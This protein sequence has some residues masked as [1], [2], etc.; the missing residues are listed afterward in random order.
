MF[1]ARYDINGLGKPLEDHLIS[2]S[3]LTSSNSILKLY[4]KIIGLLHDIGKYSQAF[5]DYLKNAQN[6]DE[7]YEDQD[8]RG[9][10]D[11]SS[12]GAQFIVKTMREISAQTGDA[13]L[14]RL[15]ELIARIV[16]H[17]VAGHHSGLLNGLTPEYG[18]SLEKRLTK[19]LE[20]YAKN[21]APEIRNK[22][23]LLAGALLEDDNLQSICSWIDE[24]ANVSGRDAFSLQFAVRMLFSALVDADRLHSEK[25]GNPDQWAERQAIRTESPLTLLKKLEDHLETLGKEGSMNQIRRQVSK[26][27]RDAGTQDRGFF[28]LTVPTGGGKT[29]ASLRFAL[30]HAIKH[31]LNRIIY[32]IPYTSIIDQNAEVFRGVMDADGK[33]NNVLE[34]HSNLEPKRET[35]E[36]RLLA[37][38]WN[39]P[40]VVTTSVQFFESLF[41]NRPSPCRRLHSVSNSVVILDEVQTVPVRYLQAITWALEELVENY[42]CTVMLCTATQPVLDSRKI[43]GDNTKDNH[44]IGLQNIHPIID[45]PAKL[46]K[47][48]KRVKILEIESENPLSMPEIAERIIEHADK[49]KSVLSIVNTKRNASALFSELT[50][51]ERFAGRLF[52]LSTTMCP[53]HRKDVIEIIKRLS[54]Y[55][56]NINAHGP[57]VISTQLVEAGIDLDFD[58]VFRSM[59]GVDSIAQAAGRCNREGVLLPQ[60]GKTY[61]YE[62]NEYLGSLI[63][64]IEA[65][66]AG[67]N[68]LSAIENNPNLSNEEKDPLGLKAVQ[69]YFERLYWSR[70]DEMDKESIIARLTASRKLEHA[71]DI[72]FA[73]IGNDFRIIKEDTM[74]VVVPYGIQGKLVINELKQGRTLEFNMIRTVQQHSVQ[75]YQSALPYYKS[76]IEETPAGWLVVDSSVH[77]GKIGLR[78]PDNIKVEDYIL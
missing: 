76:I 38:N 21:I 49:G 19:P 73:D 52:H 9:K 17:C 22:I 10:V 24:D 63:D 36:S 58:I 28:Q 20:P 16:G 67:M 44:R 1:C 51:E 2:A 43:D 78:R 70:R 11:H 65:K 32:V 57:I 41:T 56:R 12:A 4:G 42:R 55:S 50:R 72:P 48:L 68:T 13:E 54:L 25:T 7:E 35:Q 27:C 69:E 14:A 40:I 3:E 59:A 45:K 47:S 62:A 61:I 46:F 8:I 33:T 18:P 6:G 5:Q 31:K 26:Q 77:Y 30:H 75:V 37:E 66:H 29:L 34:H 71:T 64:I 15:A 53:Q 60:L 23:E 74:S 39:A